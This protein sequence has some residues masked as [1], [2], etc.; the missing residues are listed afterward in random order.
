MSKQTE[1]NSGGDVAMKSVALPPV[2][3]VFL[4]LPLLAILLPIPATPQSTLTFDVASIKPVKDSDFPGQRFRNTPGSLE[5]LN[6][7]PTTIIENA[8]RL[9]MPGQLAGFPPW[10]DH[11]C[12]NIEA[13]VDTQDPT[14]ELKQA[15]DQNLL[16]LQSL[17]AD[18]F[19]LK[20]HWENRPQHA[21]VLAVVEDKKKSSRLNPSSSST[22][23][24][25]R[26]GQG[27]LLCQS[28]SMSTLAVF[29][30]SFLQKPVEDQTGIQ[31]LYD[32]NLKFEPPDSSALSTDDTSLPSLFTL[33][34]DQLGLKL[35]PKNI[36]VQTLIVDHIEHPR[37]N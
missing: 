10:A 14:I 27:T 29:L 2:Q 23:H 15:R 3:I 16:R 1:L 28:C 33:L 8:Y 5:I 36:L 25:T 24:F 4:L 21:Y 18:R 12:Y 7:E 9:T 11:D 37:P 34:K 20:T 17:L 32:F 31:G 26:Q 30:S 35:K 19:Q 6:M 22:A 13:R